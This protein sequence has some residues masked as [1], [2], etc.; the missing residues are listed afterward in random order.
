MHTCFVV[1]SIAF[2]QT[3]AAC[4]ASCHCNTSTHPSSTESNKTLEIKRMARPNDPNHTIYNKKKAH[5]SFIAV[6]ALRA[7]H[8][9]QFHERRHGNVES[10]GSPQLSSHNHG[11]S[12]VSPPPKVLRYCAVCW[13]LQLG[14][15]VRLFVVAIRELLERKPVVW[16][17]K[18]HACDILHR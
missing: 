4:R 8:L 17:L 5:P 2:L 10:T 14:E 1:E 7:A 16:K 12:T 15:A 3:T 9:E 18:L 6:I 13:I 11:I